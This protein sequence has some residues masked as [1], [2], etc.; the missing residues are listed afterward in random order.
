MMGT[1]ESTFRLA[2][3]TATR[4]ARGWLGVEFTPVI[5]W[6]EGFL[7]LENVNITRAVVYSFGPAPN[8]RNWNF[9]IDDLSS[10]EATPFPN[11]P[12]CSCSARAWAGSS[13]HG[14]GGST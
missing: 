14:D 13:L 3:T 9:S 5:N 10:R 4:F 1:L 7:A 2:V 8:Y 12:R 11:P 6:M